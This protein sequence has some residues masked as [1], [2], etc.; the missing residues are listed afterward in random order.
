MRSWTATGARLARSLAL[1]LCLLPAAMPAAA[2]EPIRAVAT[3][4]ILGDLVRQ[5]G[6]A[7]VTVTD[8]VGPDADAHGYSPAPGDSRTLAAADIVFV[9]GLG[10]EGWMDRLIL[11]SGAKAP[12]VIASRGVTTIPAH[13]AHAGEDSRG[14]VG[15]HAAEG[16]TVDPHAW[17]SLANAEVYVAN[18]RDGLSKA[19][20]TNAAA[21]GR[22]A[23]GYL[24]TLDTFATEVRATLATIPPEHRR[25]ITTHDAFGYFSAAYGLAFLAPQGVSTESEAS[26]Q[27]VARIIRQIRRDKVPAVFIETI[28]DPR[29]MQ[30][31]A[32]ESGARIG[33]KVYSDALSGPDGPASTYL[34]MMR[35]NLRAFGAALAPR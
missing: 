10:F 21:Y 33:G 34:D 3:F 22:N 5:V 7:T 9:N 8:L 25:V 11:A 26:P 4:S 23:E 27:D 15:N 20:P 17:Q 13:H 30:Q 18:I 14:G 32:R 29:L 35:N 1:L 6:G 19:D 16:S 12:V 31:I 28:A 2:G 24:A